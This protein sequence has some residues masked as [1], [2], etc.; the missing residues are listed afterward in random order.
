MSDRTCTIEGCTRKLDSKGLCQ[1][2]ISRKRRGQPMEGPI[3]DRGSV[4]GSCS[5]DGCTKPITAT[6]MC[7]SHYGLAYNKR[8]GGERRRQW[9]AERGDAC[10]T[11][12]GP[13]PFEID[14]IDPSSKE[15]EIGAIW[16]RRQ[17]VRD[18]E[19]AKCQVLCVDCHRAKNASEQ[20]QQH[21]IANWRRGCRC[22]VCR[23]AMDRQ[24]DLARARRKAA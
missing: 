3:R 21:G 6:G 24:L 10:A 1:A 7:A 12:G 20:P 13:G 14:H 5:T 11:C 22:G 19:L 16:L 4:A 17:E 8:V 2:H 9:I 23:D 15:M 18:H